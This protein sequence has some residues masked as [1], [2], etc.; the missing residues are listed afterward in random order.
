MEYKNPVGRPVEVSKYIRDEN[1]VWQLK[2]FA[3]GVCIGIGASF[4]E[5][6]GGPGN[7]STMIVE[8]SDGSIENKMIEHCQFLDREDSDEKEKST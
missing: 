4:E 8:L 3:K 1:C 2:P 6:D 7:F 5:V